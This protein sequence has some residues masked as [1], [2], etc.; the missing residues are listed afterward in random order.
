MAEK[1]ERELGKT[2][3]L[4]PVN[5]PETLLEQSGVGMLFDPAEGISF[6]EEYDSFIDIFSNPDTHIGGLIRKREVEDV[7]MGYLESDSISDMPFRKMAERFPDNFARVIEYVLNWEGFSVNM[8]DELMLH[9]KPQTFDKLP[10]YVAVFDSEMI[11][12][13]RLGEE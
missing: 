12:F 10:T 5:F 2:Y 6:L 7:I 4:P 3:R 9:Y 8:I 11:R 13:V 1:H